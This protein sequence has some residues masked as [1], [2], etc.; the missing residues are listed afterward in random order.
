LESKSFSLVPKKEN[1]IALC[2]EE[3]LFCEL[4]KSTSKYKIFFE[5]N[6]EMLKYH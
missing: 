2:E 5:N 3:L 6:L 1:E 4:F